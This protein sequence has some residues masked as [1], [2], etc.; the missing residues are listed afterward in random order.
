M[1]WILSPFRFLFY[2]LWLPIHVSR[3]PNSSK[4]L[5]LITALF[6]AFILFPIWVASYVFIGIAGSMGLRY[7]GI[8][9]VSIPVAGASMLPTFTEEEGSIA[10]HRYPHLEELESFPQLSSVKEQI[11]PDIQRGDVVVFKNKET[12]RVFDAQNKDPRKTGGFVKRVIGLPGDV[13][14]IRNG[15]VRVNGEIVD[16]P[17]TLKPRST[18]G[19]DVVADCSVVR[20]PPGKLFVLGDNRKVSLD[21]RHIGLISYDDVQYYI[22]YDEQLEKFAF[23]WRD[24]SNDEDSSF[25]SELDPEE[26][27][28]LLNER[29]T[30]IGKEPLTLNPKLSQSAELRAKVMLE[31]NDLS[32]EATRSGYTMEDAFEEVEYSN[33]VYGEFPILGYYDAQELIDYF[34]EYNQAQEFLMRDDYQEIG[35]SSFVGF[36]NGCPV[37]IVNQ[38]LAGFVPPEYSPAE[39]QPW[40]DLVTNLQQIREGWIKLKSSGDFYEENKRDIDR[41]NEVIRIRSANARRIVERMEKNEWLTAEEEELVEQEKEL[42]AEQNE[43]ADRLNKKIE[44]LQ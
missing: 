33:V 34:F 11:Q 29:R 40:K 9:P 38:H 36:M 20:V 22:P 19:G 23:R 12:V 1:S 43:I 44:E 24:I 4:N 5:K 14:T 15:F 8:L 17:Y 3:D 30:A 10:A 2:P 7:I 26:F 21:S 6:S 28:R 25:N 41:I 42:F 18:F 35:I 31:Y 39:I 27:V 37:Q 13:V 16:E 32:F